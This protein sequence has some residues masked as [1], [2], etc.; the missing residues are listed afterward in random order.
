MIKGK[1]RCKMIEKCEKVKTNFVI[2]EIEDFGEKIKNLGDE[3][4][5]EFITNWA[6]KLLAETRSFDIGKIQISLNKFPEMVKH[7][8]SVVNKK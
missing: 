7:I 4:Q 2:G 6:A 8:N 3:Y 5:I 1:G